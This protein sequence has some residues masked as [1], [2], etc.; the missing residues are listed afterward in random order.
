[1]EILSSYSHV[2]D[3]P[4]PF[5]SHPSPLP[6][7]PAPSLHPP[8]PHRTFLLPSLPLPYPFRPSLHLSPPVLTSPHHSPPAPSPFRSFTFRPNISLA[9]LPR[10][11]F[12][13]F[14]CR[15]KISLTLSQKYS[16]DL[17]SASVCRAALGGW[18]S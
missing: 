13:F 4:S 7:P 1:M 15:G 14:L 6:T 10:K 3:L 5:S 18:P 12:R 9:R 17:D 16:H 2:N 11:T 8:V